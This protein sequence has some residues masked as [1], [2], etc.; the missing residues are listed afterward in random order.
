MP[1]WM[2]IALLFLILVLGLFYAQ[3]NQL[4]NIGRNHGTAKGRY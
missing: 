3:K 1:K 2:I 4:L